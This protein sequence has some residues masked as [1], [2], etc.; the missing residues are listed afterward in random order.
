MGFSDL[1]LVSPSDERVLGRKKCIDGASGAIDILKEAKVFD[2]LEDAFDGTDDDV[3]ICGTGMPV[4]MHN[5]RLPQMYVAPRT[6]FQELLSSDQQLKNGNGNGSSSPLEAKEKNIK[7][8][9]L[10]G[11]ERVGMKPEDMERCNVMLGIPTN[12]NFGSLN[13]ASAVQIIAYDWREAIGG[14][15]RNN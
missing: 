8:A 15:E 2:N 3:I 7:I 12:P 13:L 11:N 9:F 5:E 4:S 1:I 10:F 6:F 14:Y